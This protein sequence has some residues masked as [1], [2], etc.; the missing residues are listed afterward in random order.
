MH[1][2]GANAR[3]ASSFVVRRFGAF[4]EISLIFRAF[5]R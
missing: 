5:H 2:I 4:S 1:D 3:I